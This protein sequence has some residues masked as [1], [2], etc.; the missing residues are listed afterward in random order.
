M[1]NGSNW[2]N[3]R[4]SAPLGGGSGVGDVF[5]SMVS[6]CFFTPNGEE[7]H[8]LCELGF[9]TEGKG[10]TFLGEMEVVLGSPGVGKT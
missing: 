10:V 6:V 8:S 1:I 9:D 3:R 7:C 5:L 2:E 4:L